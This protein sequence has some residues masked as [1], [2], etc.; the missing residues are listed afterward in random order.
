MYELMPI[1]CSLDLTTLQQ[2]PS[3]QHQS[4]S[5][6]EKLYESDLQEHH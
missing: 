6:L 1:Q 3:I 4:C 5:E 2:V